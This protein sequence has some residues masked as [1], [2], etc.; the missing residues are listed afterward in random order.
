MS[1]NHNSFRQSFD[2]YFTL[3]QLVLVPYVSPYLV[4]IIFSFPS[5]S[6]GP[7]C[8]FESGVLLM[9]MLEGLSSIVNFIT[10]YEESE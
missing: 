9:Y 8:I 2:F 10:A 1:G 5:G 7:L 4:Q 6:L 3:L